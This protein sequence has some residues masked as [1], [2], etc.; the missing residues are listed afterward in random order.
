MFKLNFPLIQLYPWSNPLK[1]FYIALLG[2]IKKLADLIEG[3]KVD[4]IDNCGH[5]MLLEEADRVLKVLKSFVLENY[6]P[7]ES[8][9][10]KKFQI[11]W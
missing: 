5:M 11:F 8:W 4:I 7:K 10:E 3:S 6:P 1:L 9:N 2:A